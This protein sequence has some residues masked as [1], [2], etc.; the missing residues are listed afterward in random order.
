MSRVRHR[1]AVN[2][3]GII[4]AFVTGILADAGVSV[5]ARVLCRQHNEAYLGYRET[6]TGYLIQPASSW[7][8][9]REGLIEGVDG[10]A[11]WI[12]VR[13]DVTEAGLESD[14]YAQYFRHGPD[15]PWVLYYLR[16]RPDE[17]RYADYLL[18]AD[19]SV[20]SLRFVSESEDDVE[21]PS[22]VQYE[23]DTA[24]DYYDLVPVLGSSIESSES[25]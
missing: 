1:I 15:S 2:A 18:R 11:D 4:A 23:F 6:D 3:A 5:V 19:G 7:F 8:S 10:D 25:Q 21:A 9:Y 16:V 20:E 24:A 12:E 13:F 22:S 14:S 17:G